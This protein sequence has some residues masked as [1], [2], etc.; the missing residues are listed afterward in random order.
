MRNL[1]MTATKTQAIG[2]GN[3][4]RMPLYYSIVDN[5][6]YTTPAQGRY[7]VTDLLRPNTP[8]EIETAVNRWL[9]M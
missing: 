3:R 5:A 2:K 1:N 6:V 9:A 8:E 4:K 7:Y